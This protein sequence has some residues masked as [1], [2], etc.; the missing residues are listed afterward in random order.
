MF[1]PEFALRPVALGGRLQE[2]CS[3]SGAPCRRLSAGRWRARAS[4]ASRR[5]R[6]GPRAGPARSARPLRR[7]RP[8]GR[9]ISGRAEPSSRP[10]APGRCRS[11]PPACERRR[12][13]V[14]GV[15]GPMPKKSRGAAA[16][17]AG[18]AS[19][20]ST[21]AGRGLWCWR[22][23]LSPRK[24]GR[25]GSRGRTSGRAGSARAP[26][27]TRAPRRPSAGCGRRASRPAGRRSAGW[28]G[29]PTGR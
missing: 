19:E 7:A 27:P 21:A 5:G 29:G 13:A 28:P 17:V 8:S 12:P 23:S 4:A 16:A 15:C 10:P 26:A 22:V 14:S 25:R 3:R 24:P 1:D 9:P 20:P 18:T 2:R 11:R 6:A